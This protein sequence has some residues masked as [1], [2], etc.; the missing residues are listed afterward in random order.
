MAFVLKDSQ[1]LLGQHNVTSFT[2]G[3]DMQQSCTVVEWKPHGNDGYVEKYPGI[4][5][6][7]H[8]LNGAADF[9]ASGIN[10]M[11]NPTTVGTQYALTLL[12]NGSATAVGGPAIFTRGILS[13]F[14]APTGEVDTIAGF[15]LTV[16]SDTAEVNGV[17]GLPLAARTSTTTGSVI[18]MAGPTASQKLYA[19]LNIT[20]VSGTTPAL[21]ATIQSATLVGFGSPTT[22]A[23]FT[24]ANAAGWQW[25]TP[26]AGAITDG[27]W[28]VVFTI[29]G[30]TPSFTAACSFGVL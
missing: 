5:T 25:L 21:V 30:T 1:F 7:T 16:D 14:K 11:I 15:S 13:D 6:Y 19:S 24:S 2:G 26:V 29:S 3:H 8:S 18:T 23:T 27:F 20:A 10:S 17:C 12:P 4:K 22:R 28:R 9:S